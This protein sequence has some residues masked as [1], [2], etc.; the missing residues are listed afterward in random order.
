MEWI[1]PANLR[2]YDVI[3][4]FRDLKI[5]DWSQSKNFKNLSVGDIVYI[6][7]GKHGKNIGYVKFKCKVLAVN[8]KKI[9]HNDLK[10]YINPNLFNQNG[11]FAELEAVAEFPDGEEP[12][13]TELQKNGLNGH[14]QGSRKISAELAEYLDEH[15]TISNKED[16]YSSIVYETS[17]EGTV[18]YY[19]THKYERNPKLRGAAI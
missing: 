9:T 8:K 10:Y 11:I 16:F 7:I 12:T 14:P 4:A 19:Y 5:I 15:A 3:N 17:N 18:K 6:Y 13:L 2:I 1:T